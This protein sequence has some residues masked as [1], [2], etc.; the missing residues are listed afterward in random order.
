MIIKTI[1]RVC[2]EVGIHLEIILLRT[3]SAKWFFNFNGSYR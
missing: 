3:F 2:N 1:K